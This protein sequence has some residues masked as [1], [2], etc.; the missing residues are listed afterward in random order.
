MRVHA[1]DLANGWAA[2]A[3]FGPGIAVKEPGGLCS[4][5]KQDSS[6]ASELHQT[7]SGLKA[8]AHSCAQRGV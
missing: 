2:W 4:S 6:R 3:D 8:P 5:A 1:T 7:T